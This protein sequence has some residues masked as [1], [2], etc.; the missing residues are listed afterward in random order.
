[1][2]HSH[3]TQAVLRRSDAF[4]TQESHNSFFTVPCFVRVNPLESSKTR[5]SVAHGANRVSLI[6]LVSLCEFRS[7]A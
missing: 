6:L 5:R 3:S 2:D 7:K 4:Q 1:M